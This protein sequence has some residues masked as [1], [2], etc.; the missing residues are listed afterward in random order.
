MYLYEEKL[1]VHGTAKREKHK[2]LAWSAAIGYTAGLEINKNCLE[3]KK[4]VL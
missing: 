3:I 1:S 2:M 4:T